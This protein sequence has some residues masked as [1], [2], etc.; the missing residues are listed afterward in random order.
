M[1][2]VSIIHPRDVIRLVF[3][4]DERISR[5]DAI[6]PMLR[7]FE[8]HRAIMPIDPSAGG[9]WLAASDAGMIF[10]IL[11]RN[12]PGFTSSPDAISRGEIIPSLLHADA[13]EE[14]V[15]CACELNLSRYS[16]FRL[17]MLDAARL[18][19]LLWDGYS[20]EIRHHDLD[21]PLMFTSSGLGD[22]LVDAPRRQLFDSTLAARPTPSRQD[23]FH[24]H[25][26]PDRRHLSVWMS[27]ADARTVSITTVE[28]GEQ[29]IHLSYQPAKEG[30]LDD[31]QTLS[32]PLR[33]L[34]M[35]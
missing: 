12:L 13:V 27:R 11:N 23:S 6:A 31:A 7:E 1:C 15:D 20:P 10:A 14:A 24:H 34:R 16:P 9:T 17:L 8:P 5:P 26:W 22:S 2:T 4:R 21:G 33:L 3:S 18:V 28:L 25:T 19:E 29:R 35:A 30:S 32:L